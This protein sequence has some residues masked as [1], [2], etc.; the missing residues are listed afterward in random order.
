MEVYNIPVFSKNV[1]T[2]SVCSVYKQ[3]NYG[4]LKQTTE[5]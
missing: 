4:Y 1:Y 5:L 3:R 2:D